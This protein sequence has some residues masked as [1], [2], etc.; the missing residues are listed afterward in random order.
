[1]GPGYTMTYDDLRELYRKT[2][3]NGTVFEYSNTIKIT[4]K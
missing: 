1:M 4:T 2:V 3:S